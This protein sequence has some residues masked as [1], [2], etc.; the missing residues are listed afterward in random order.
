[1]GSA[2]AGLLAWCRMPRGRLVLSAYLGVTVIS[3][4]ADLLGSAVLVA[5]R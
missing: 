2:A 5:T 3:A 1:M 4:V